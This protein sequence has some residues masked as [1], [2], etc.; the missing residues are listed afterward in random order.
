MIYGAN[1]FKTTME[2]VPRLYMLGFKLKQSAEPHTSFNNLKLVS[3][4][5][6]DPQGNQK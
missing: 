2:A 4:G 3:K 6:S 5:Y 1:P